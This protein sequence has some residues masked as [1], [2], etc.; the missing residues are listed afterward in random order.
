MAQLATSMVLLYVNVKKTFTVD[1]KS[2]Y[3]FTPKHLTEWCLSLVRYLL[4]EDDKS[5]KSVLEAWAYEA[6][7]LFRYYVKFSVNIYNFVRL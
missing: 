3:T 4:N 5:P 2:H 1:D 6:C 7:R